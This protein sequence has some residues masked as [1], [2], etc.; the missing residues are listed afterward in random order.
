MGNS[1]FDAGQLTGNLAQKRRE[2][3]LGRFR[4]GKLQYLVATDVAARGIDIIELSHVFQFDVPLDPEYYIHRTGRTARAGNAGTAVVLSTIEDDRELL[5]IAS[6][7]GIELIEKPMPTEE[8]VT[9]RVSERAVVLL[10][11]QLRSKT[12]LERERL[13]RLCAIGSRAGE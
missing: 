5:S 1:G 9:K 12:N 7:Y 6:R 2:E 10:E 3:V 11:K 4:R 8:D 13:Q